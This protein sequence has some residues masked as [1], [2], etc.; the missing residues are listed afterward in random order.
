MSRRKTGKSVRNL[1]SELKER[2]GGNKG[3]DLEL[4]SEVLPLCS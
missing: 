2:D 3:I 1:L 4:G